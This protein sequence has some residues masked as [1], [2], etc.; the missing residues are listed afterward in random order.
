MQNP[1]TQNP[2][3]QD[4]ATQDP[5]TQDP[6]MQHS[7]SS[8][9]AL[10]VV[11]EASLESFPASD[12]PGWGSHRAAAAPVEAPVAPNE[13]QGRAVSPAGPAATPVE[14][15]AVSPRPGV[16]RRLARAFR[17]HILGHDP[18]TGTKG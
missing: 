4:P 14:A 3:T 18:D 2:A 9:E 5:A 6:N 17:R 10:D 1:T 16:L 12:P 13:P 15:P 11:D 8:E 7:T